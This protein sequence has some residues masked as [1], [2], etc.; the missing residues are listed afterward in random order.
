MTLDGHF[1]AECARVLGMLGH[2]DLLDLLAEGCAVAVK[3]PSVSVAIAPPPSLLLFRSGCS[4]V[5]AYRVPY[6]PV[7][8]TFLVPVKK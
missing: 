8:P 3:Y 7:I 4:W 2:F 6:L 5:G 1:A